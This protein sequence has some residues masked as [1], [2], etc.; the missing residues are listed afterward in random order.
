MPI[1]AFIHGATQVLILGHEKIHMQNM[2]DSC[3]Y[4]C[5]NMLLL[6]SIPLNYIIQDWDDLVCQGKSI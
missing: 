4:I 1:S 2:I 3:L 5:L 6:L